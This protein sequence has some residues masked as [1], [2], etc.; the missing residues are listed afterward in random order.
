MN[1]FVLGV[2]IGGTHI[3]AAI[4]DLATRKILHETMTRQKVDASGTIGDIMTSWSSAM[5]T[6][7]GKHKTEITNIGIA[8]PG[9]FDYE[10]GIALMQN[11]DKYDA[12]YGINVKELLAEALRLDNDNI[13]FQ[14]DAPCFL[15]GEAF[16][17]AAQGYNRAVGLTLG[18]GLGSA[19][20][21]NGK[22]WDANL[23][24]T[25]FRDGI[26][27]EH[28]SSRWFVKRFYELSG[29]K[30]DNVK[31]I[32]ELLPTE[33]KVQELF[34]EYA[35]NLATFLGDFVRQEQPEVIILGGNIAK[36]FN[37]FGGGLQEE[38][39]AQ[40]IT[41]P[42]KTAQLGEEAALLGAASLWQEPTDL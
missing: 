22:A 16:A 19:V 23:W 2:D 28:L 9:P 27:E 1:Q 11:Q 25:P 37:L 5:L 30:A 38:L 42:I 29:R 12:L 10:N 15:K 41:I 26:A 32:V 4:V 6:A 14:N 24:D 8:M 20:I 7:I 33:P 18:T 34:T 35:D 13:R 36:G 40:R 3:T 31:T 21:V 39:Q 17:G